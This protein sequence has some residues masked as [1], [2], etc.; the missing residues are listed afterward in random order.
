MRRLFA[1]PARLLVLRPPKIA[2]SISELRASSAVVVQTY[3]TDHVETRQISS[4]RQIIIGTADP[5]EEADFLEFR[6]LYEGELLPSG[7]SHKRRSE[8]H[9]IRRSFHPQLKR[10]WSVHNSLRRLAARAGNHADPRPGTEE[11]QFERGI[12][13]IGKQWARVGYQFAPLV[14]PEHA[15]RCSIEML[16]LRPEEDRYIF[17]RGDIDGQLKTIFDAFQVPQTQQDLGDA[18]P[19]SGETPFFCLLADDKLISEVRVTTDQLLLL[20][21][22]KTVKANDCF[23]D[24]CQTELQNSENI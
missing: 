20:P 14:T 22:H 3:L 21:T 4:Y 17:T 18:T 5:L 6:L 24:S 7:N 16:L 11:E 9:E 12:N 15:L 1:F 13:A 8:K 19:Q 23:P 2:P 10:L